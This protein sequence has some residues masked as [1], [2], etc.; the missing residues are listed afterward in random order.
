MGKIECYCEA[1]WLASVGSE[2]RMHLA[3]AKLCGG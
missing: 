2:Q 3:L 1:Q